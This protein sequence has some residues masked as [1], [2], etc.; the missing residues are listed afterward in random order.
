MTIKVLIARNEKEKEDA[1]K[2]RYEVFTESGLARCNKT[3]K[4]IDEF[5]HLPTTDHIITYDGERPVGACRLLRENPMQAKK[6]GTKLGLRIESE[7]ILSS[8]RHTL[9]ELSRSSVLHEYRSKPVLLKMY[10]TLLNHC[11]E[12]GIESLLTAITSDT[13]CVED[14]NLMYQIGTF[15]DYHTK[16]MQLVPRQ[17]LC[18]GPILPQKKYF[19]SLPCKQTTKT[20]WNTKDLSEKLRLGSTKLGMQF[21]GEPVYD[22]LYQICVLPMYW[23]VKNALHT[24]VMQYI[25]KQTMQEV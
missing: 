2:V 11:Q 9:G 23:N 16:D 15:L 24:P 17:E 14:A 1:F 7:F 19:S 13:D 25:R 4:D 20:Q 10:A 21:C 22:P 12:K 5:D 6:D 3:C 18:Q 8:P